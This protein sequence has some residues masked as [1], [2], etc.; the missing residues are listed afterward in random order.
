MLLSC[1]L[2]SPP[3]DEGKCKDFSSRHWSTQCLALSSACC[4]ARDQVIFT[5][6][7]DLPSMKGSRR[8][9]FMYFLQGPCGKGRT[10]IR[11]PW[12]PC[13]EYRPDPTLV[14]IQLWEGSLWRQE[15]ILGVS[16]ET[17]LEGHVVGPGQGELAAGPCSLL[18]RVDELVVESRGV[19]QV[20]MCHILVSGA[21]VHP[22]SHSLQLRGAE[23]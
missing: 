18:V 20:H 7:K 6:G 9:C 13:W 2:W 12:V 17:G 21:T 3:G 10:G 11:C 19:P 8:S 14:S 16:P 23:V 15:N 1:Q 5:R 4:E 22:I